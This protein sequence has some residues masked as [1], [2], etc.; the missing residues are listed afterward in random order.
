MN[1]LER[2]QRT[3]GRNNG[4]ATA[5]IVIK[6]FPHGFDNITSLAIRKIT[7][8]ALAHVVNKLAASG[9]ESKYIK[10]FERGYRIGLRNRFTEHARTFQIG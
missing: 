2:D 9:I 8:D 10:P 7:D 6:Q 3:A 1:K 5:E 4:R